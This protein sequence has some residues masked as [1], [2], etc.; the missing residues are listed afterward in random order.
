MVEELIKRKADVN[1]LSINGMSPLLIAA[2]KRQSRVLS[3]LLQNGVDVKYQS[4]E[5]GNTALHIACLM[6]D[7]QSVK[8]LINFQ[9]SE[10]DQTEILFQKNKTGEIAL[11]LAKRTQADT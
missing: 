3:M 6:H 9:M 1:A 2:E 8:T 10:A 11:D 4:S 7:F 5:S